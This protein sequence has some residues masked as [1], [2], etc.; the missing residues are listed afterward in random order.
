MK[1]R[2][3]ALFLAL[4]MMFSL[5]ACGGSGPVGVYSL[6]SAKVPGMNEMSVADL[7]ALIGTTV[8][9]T[10]ALKADGSF[11]L[12][13]NAGGLESETVEGTW[14]A[15]GSELTLSS[16]GSDVSAT[17]TGNAVVMEEDGISMTFKR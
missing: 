7:S 9:G 11:T 15:E 14:T 1:K 16:D 3:L 12:E 17:L 4:A 6:S 8:S 2:T 5:A 10:L 13:M